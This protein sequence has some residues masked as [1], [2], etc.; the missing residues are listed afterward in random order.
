MKDIKER[1]RRC[2]GVWCV[3]ALC[4]FVCVCVCVYGYRYIEIYRYIIA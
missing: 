4:V 2:V 1:S 3:F